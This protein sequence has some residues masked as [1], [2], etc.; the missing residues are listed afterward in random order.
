VSQ[1]DRVFVEDPSVHVGNK[2]LF[3]I[4]KYEL[5]RGDR[6]DIVVSRRGL[7]EEEHQARAA[8]LRKTIE[9][10]KVMHGTV[11]TIKEYGA[12]VDLGG[13]EGMLHVSELGFQRVKHPSELLH[14]GQPLEVQDTKIEK[15][16]DPKRPEK[17]SLS[18]KALEK[19][20]W[21]D[22]AERYPEGAKVQG[23]VTRFQPFG[24]FVELEPG[25]EGLIH[26][27]QMATGRRI[28]H[29]REA[30]ELGQTVEATVVQV[31]R[32]RR[33]L[34]LSLTAGSPS[35]EAGAADFARVKAEARQGF[36]TFA[37]LMKPKA[38]R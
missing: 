14:V 4:T 10:G 8:E 36:G 15:T 27:S 13:L 18:L 34:A 9:V 37:D 26:L 30:V 31:D 22:V 12:F 5:G 3:R 2:Y 23:R 35:D 17:I 20:P 33:R 1:I 6:P 21:E 7:L 25:V 16:D 24:A 32:E 19:D 28:N 38:K 29:P 11:T